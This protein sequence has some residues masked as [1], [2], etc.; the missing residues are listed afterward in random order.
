MVQAISDV[1]NSPH[2]NAANTFVYDAYGK[3]IASIDPVGNVKQSNYGAFENL[4]S[5]IADFGPGRLNV[6]TSLGYDT[7]GNITAIT[8]ANGRTKTMAYDG[9]RRLLTTTA[10]APFNA[11][12]TLVQTANAYDADG[13]LTSVTRS[14]GSTN[15]LVTTSYTPTGKVLA[16]TDANNNR[17]ARTY[18]LNDRLQSVT[19]PVSAGINRVT[20]F[21]YDAMNRLTSTHY[22]K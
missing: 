9:A 18:D 2:F 14:N 21:N 16:V 6:T 11:G 15:Q 13:H 8:D 7:T 5:S 4:T 19:Q 12:S 17:T 3:A 20:R 1:G 22:P 10:P